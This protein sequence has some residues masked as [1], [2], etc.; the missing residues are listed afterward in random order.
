[1][2]KLRIRRQYAV[3][4]REWMGNF[5]VNMEAQSAE[6]GA[7]IAHQV[8]LVAGPI[9]KKLESTINAKVGTEA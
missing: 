5:H 1:M 4:L 3:K 7:A 9:A 2:H 8:R 6:E